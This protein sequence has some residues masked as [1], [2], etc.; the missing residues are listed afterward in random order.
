MKKI[1]LMAALLLLVLLGGCSSAGESGKIRIGLLPIVDSLP[2]VVAEEKGYFRAE[3]VDVELL[4]F[5]SAVERDSALQ[6][7]AIDGTLGD[8]LA[9]ASL[10]QGG[11]PTRIV[12]LGLGETGGEGRF[13]I[14][15]APGSGITKPEDLKNIPVAVSLNSI[16]EYITDSLLLER[17]FT[18]EEIK[19]E[20]IPM[21]PVRYEML[22]NGQIKAACLPD[23]LATLAQ[24]KGAVLVIDDTASNLSQT[25]IYFRNDFLDRNAKN[26]A[27]FMKAYARAVKDIDE[28]P[29][30]YKSTLAEKIKVPPEALAVFEVDHF[31]LPQMPDKG[32]L[33]KVV[34]W[35]AAKGLLKKAPTYE[36]LTRP[37]FLPAN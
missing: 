15:A 19:K 1:P 36:E 29:N 30:A 16:I 10:N 7:R 28:N 14:L 13:A 26:V 21:I 4:N 8:V 2:F 34:G 17:G 18:Q 6:A 20:S 35:M 32:Q 37:G 12:S 31:P 24:K 23:P 25:V 9:V 22:M 33:E 3:G 27:R 11:V 5:T